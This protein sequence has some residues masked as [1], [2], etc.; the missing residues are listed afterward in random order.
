MTDGPDPD[1]GDDL[2]ATALARKGLANLPRDDNDAVDGAKLTD[3]IAEH[4]PDPD[5]EAIKRNRARA[6]IRRLRGHG[7]TEP[8]G[9]LTFDNLEPW[10]Y[11][12]DR[13]VLANDGAVVEQTRAKPGAKRDESARAMRKAQE[14]MTQA[15]RRTAEAAAFDE[16][17]LTRI[18]SGADYAADISFGAFVA[19]QRQQ[20]NGGDS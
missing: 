6:V 8:D 16:W 11:E 19:W 2:D 3:Y 1:D 5:V 7:V 13:L 17:A 14:T 20:Q 12:P 15:R 9:Q 10:D 4:L 18:R